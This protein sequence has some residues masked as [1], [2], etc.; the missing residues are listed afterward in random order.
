MPKIY[1][2]FG[3]SFYFWANEHL[4]IH[5]HI[6]KGDT[7]AVAVFIMDK[8]KLAD[9]KINKRRGRKMLSPA[10]ESEA[11]KLLFAKQDIIVK[12]WTDFY[13]TFTPIRPITITKRIK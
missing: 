5:V 1:Q 3:M 12:R 4:P 13:V 10:D 9:I 7:E 6:E 11:R 2:Y 8:G